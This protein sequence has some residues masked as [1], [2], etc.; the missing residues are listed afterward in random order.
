MSEIIGEVSTEL[1]GVVV[2][3]APRAAGATVFPVL[4]GASFCHLLNDMIQSLFLAA[5]P[6]FKGGFDLS[7]AQIGL[8]TL[9]YQATASLLQPI[10]GIYTDRPIRCPSAW[11]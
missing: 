8:L 7:F 2:V 4:A 11:G 6:I 9:V 5:Y 3:E 1:S 10:I